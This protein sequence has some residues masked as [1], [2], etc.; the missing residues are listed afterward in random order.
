MEPTTSN[1]VVGSTTATILIDAEAS[2]P[3]E[4]LELV[5]R[6]LGSGAVVQPWRGGVR[7][8]DLEALYIV[9]LE[10]SQFKWRLCARDCTF[11]S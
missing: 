6:L 2:I 9:I 11:K 3:P 7:T 10:I 8:G 1:E 4:I 5:R